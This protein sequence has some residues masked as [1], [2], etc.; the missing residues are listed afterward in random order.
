VHETQTQRGQRIFKQT[1]ELIEKELND[2]NP[3]VRKAKLDILIS[4]NIPVETMSEN[5][6]LHTHTFFSYNALGWS[7]TRYAWEASKA[8][9]YAAGSID[10]DV[11][12]GVQEFLDAAETLQLRATT[13]CEVR[14]Y[15]KEF[16]DVDIDS[17]GEPGV[18]YIAGSGF[19]SLPA[20]G[21]A[22]AKT[23]ALFRQT[24]D[25]RNRDLIT[26]INRH[27][28][29]IAL[30][31]AKDVQPHTPSGNATE[32]HIISAYVD[33][34]IT[35]FP[36]FA[37]F[38]EFWAEIFNMPPADVLTAYTDRPNF[39]EKVRAKLAKSG[40][41]GYEK[42]GPQ[43]FP[44]VGSVYAWIKACG[45]IPMDSWLDGTSKGES[46]AQELFECNRSLGARAL[47]LIPDR[48]WNVRDPEIKRKKLENLARVI[49]LAEA[50]HM[51]LNIGTEGN[52]AG[53]PFVDDL[54]R[55]EFVPF[56]HAFIQGAKILIGHALLGRFADYAY[57]GEAAESDFSNNVKKKN[58]FFESVGALPPLGH[59]SAMRLREMGPK[60]A[61]EDIRHS[62]RTGSWRR[63]M[64]YEQT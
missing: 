5:V 8:G 60:L 32:R 33:K 43:T 36:R 22:E 27:V 39:E 15:L 30:D 48:N 19:T 49:A 46:Q 28:G 1:V 13:G 21:S 6:N 44:E 42:P 41:L 35:V 31:Y 64:A 9:L 29:A 14:G 11:L 63:E 51:P 16:S 23:L 53:L 56:K 7:P 50:A 10:F 3:A 26:R 62:A 18:H 4:L 12:D 58:A 37:N 55:P 45:A 54:S 59:T 57:L 38:V 47:N 40:G 2:F 61:L 25:Q 17:P 24:A 52:K 20:V 34:S